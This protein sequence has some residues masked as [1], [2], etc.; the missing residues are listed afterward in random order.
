MQNKLKKSLTLSEI[1]SFANYFY[2]FYSKNNWKIKNKKMIDWKQHCIFAINNWKI[3]APKQG[4]VL[5]EI[6]KAFH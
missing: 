1:N 3:N 5:D 4:N 2:D 6:H